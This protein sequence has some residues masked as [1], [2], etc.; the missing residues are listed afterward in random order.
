MPD[1]LIE[2]AKFPSDSK[3]DTD[4][5]LVE[6]VKLV[7]VGKGRSGIYSNEVLKNAVT[8]YEGANV[9]VNHHLRENGRFVPY[10]SRF[11]LILNPRF[12]EGDGIYGDL[13]YNPHH[14]EAKSF[15]WWAKN[16]PKSVGLSHISGGKTRFTA[17]GPLV[18]S[19]SNVKSVDLVA[20]SA[21]TEGLFESEDADDYLWKKN[22]PDGKGEGEMD[23][24][25]LTLDELRGSRPD[26]VESVLL[27]SKDAVDQKAIM[28]E[29]DSLK[30]EL[31]KYQVKEALTAKRSKAVEL[32]E[33]AELPKELVSDV[34][35]ES[36]VAT[37][38]AE[39][40]QALVDDRKSIEK[41][42]TGKPRSIPAHLVESEDFDMPTDPKA[43]KLAF[44]G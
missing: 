30:I 31:D 5:G 7:G 6:G 33:A 15:G 32:C 35:V 37:D 1:E 13:Q 20:D 19:I 38:S 2:S 18:E 21:S 26:L 41:S 36:L 34:F 8:L 29:R 24:K 42:I 23:L 9:N 17:K 22:D 43:L 28:S 16:S 11:G 10:Q 25:S 14:D 12:V 27:E 44:A 39:T 40:M 4:K 3:V